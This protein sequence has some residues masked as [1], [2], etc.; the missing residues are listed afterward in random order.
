ML[1]SCLSGILTG[2]VLAVARAAGETAPLLLVSSIYNPNQGTTLN[3]FG[4]PLPNIPIE[5]FTES[6]QATPADH[7]RAWGAALVLMAMI[8]IANLG[9]RAM[10]ARSRRKMYR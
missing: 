6:E 5:I 7:A 8:L 10:L 1:P 9:A 3:I 4:A 2:T